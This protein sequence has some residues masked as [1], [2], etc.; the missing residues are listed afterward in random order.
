MPLTV[1]PPPPHT[2]VLRFCTSEQIGSKLIRLATGYGLRY[3]WETPSHCEAVVPDPEFG[4]AIIAAQTSYVDGAPDP[5]VR[6]FK[7]SYDFWSSW[8]VFVHFQMA[9]D[10][11]RAWIGF[12]WDKC[13]SP[14][15]SG[16]FYGFVIPWLNEHEKGA[17]DCMALQMAAL[18]GCGRW[19]KPFSKEYCAVS[20]AIGLL[21]TQADQQCVELP[22]ERTS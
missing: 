8:Q 1:P 10:M 4:H 7:P 5:G 16:A 14:F 13:G 22:P 19:E 3:L 15:D 11:H 12:L 9:P 6:R 18:Q 17:M 2:A 21:L 20:P